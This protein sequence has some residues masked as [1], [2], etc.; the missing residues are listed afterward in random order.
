MS[1]II[2]RP[3]SIGV[4]ALKIQQGSETGITVVKSDEQE[5]EA[6][7]RPYKVIFRW[8]TTARAIN[9]DRNTVFV[10]TA[11]A[12]T[13]CTNKRQARLDMQAA[14]VPVPQ[15][16]GDFTAFIHD[17]RSVPADKTFVVRP[18]EHT[19]GQNY[20][21][22]T[23]M[24]AAAHLSD[25]GSG[26]ISDHIDKIAEFRVNVVQG[27]VAQVGNK[28]L[29]DNEQSS[30]SGTADRFDNVRWGQWNMAVVNA[31]VAAAAA[32]GLDFCG[33]DVML[34]ADGR[35]YVLEC[36]SAP[37]LNDYSGQCMAYCFDYIVNNGKQAFPAMLFNS[38]DEAIHPALLDD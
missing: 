5:S 11:K 10:N 19:K 22:G 23:G 3:S 14:G 38:W 27:R 21:V 7:P 35:A 18:L 34:D 2:L 26:Y 20:F 31:A 37:W 24:E 29:T 25:I 8:G 36:N 17:N 9:H 13:W 6:T 30:W 12:I 28:V 4:A 16:W 1:S 15:T 33:V 32:G